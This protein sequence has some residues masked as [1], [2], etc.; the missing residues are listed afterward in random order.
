MECIVNTWIIKQEKYTKCN[1]SSIV[2][3]QGKY[4][5]YTCFWYALVKFPLVDIQRSY[6]ASLC[7]ALY[8]LTSS[9]C[10]DMYCWL[11]ICITLCIQSAWTTLNYWYYRNWTFNFII[12][13]GMQ[14]SSEFR[15]NTIKQ[16]HWLR[17]LF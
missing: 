11:I 17:A 5:D 6:H 16:S 7:I 2:L 8:Y 12:K 4:S 9:D 15:E 14:H 3:C 10:D 1:G 13:V